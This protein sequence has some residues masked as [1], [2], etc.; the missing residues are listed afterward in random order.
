[1]TNCPTCNEP[2]VLFCKCEK[3][4]M[5]CENKHTFNVDS[6]GNPVLCNNHNEEKNDNCPTCS[7]V[8]KFFCKCDFA[9]RCCENG[10]KWYFDSNGTKISGSTHN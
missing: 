8:A 1:M 3:R 7:N 5:M 6:N 4:D 10:H 9:E 2:A